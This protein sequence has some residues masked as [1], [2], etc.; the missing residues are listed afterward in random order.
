LTWFF[1]TTAQLAFWKLYGPG[2][3]GFVGM[4]IFIAL[5]VL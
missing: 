5:V 1:Q 3:V 4:G 2:V